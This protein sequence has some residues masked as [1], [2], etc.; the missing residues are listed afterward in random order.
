MKLQIDDAGVTIALGQIEKIDSI[1]EQLSILTN[2]LELAQPL[3]LDAKDLAEIDIA[4][5]QLILSAVLAS[6]EKGIS[7]QWKDVSSTLERTAN[8]LGLLQLLNLH[9]DIKRLN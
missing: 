4:S 3:F 9:K 1:K 5:L 2:A 6:K 7:C 8:H